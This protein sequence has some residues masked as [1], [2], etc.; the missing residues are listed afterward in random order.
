MTHKK[1]RKKEKYNYNMAAYSYDDAYNASS[2]SS[3]SA[4]DMI[5]QMTPSLTSSQTPSLTSSFSPQQPK[6]R[7]TYVKDIS[8]GRYGSIFHVYDMIEKRDVLWKCF[9][10]RNKKAYE[11]EKIMLQYIQKHCDICL[12]YYGST[13]IYD[14]NVDMSM[15]GFY[16][17]CLV[18][19]YLK[20]EDGWYTIADAIM[21]NKNIPY[22]VIR[23]IYDVVNYM[24]EKLHIVHNDLNPYNIMFNIQTSRVVLIDYGLSCFVS[25]DGNT[26]SRMCSKMKGSK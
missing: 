16:D 12:R 10:N 19:E 23:N 9:K 20:K 3:S 25:E 1:Q 5:S 22:K 6:I 8:N 4:Y 13:N 2:E 18:L 7:Y 24:H 17:E 11:N 14:I 26:S 15:Y 21:T